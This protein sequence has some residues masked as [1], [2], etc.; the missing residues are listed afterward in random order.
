MVV[1][2]LADAAENLTASLIRTDRLL[3][4]LTDAK[5]ESAA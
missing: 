1:A 2:Q 4:T 5:R 3:I